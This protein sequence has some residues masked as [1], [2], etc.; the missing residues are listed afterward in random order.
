MLG[1][2]VFGLV[3]FVC[4]AFG[5]GAVVA[6]GEAEARH[7]EM[8]QVAIDGITPE[9]ARDLML[10]RNIG[11]AEIVDCVQGFWDFVFELTAA[12]DAAWEQISSEVF[13][14][15]PDYR[16]RLNR[17]APDV[18]LEY[19][20]AGVLAAFPCPE[21]KNWLMSPL[22]FCV[23]WGQFSFSIDRGASRGINVNI[24][25]F[26]EFISRAFM[27]ADCCG[28]SEI[29]IAGQSRHIDRICFGLGFEYLSEWWGHL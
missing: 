8:L 9:F 22:V 10:A 13:A 6:A 14:L 19:T 18:F 2:M 23:E 5:A 27:L 28:Y 7:V 21:S 4:V 1:K 25:Y 12:V 3:I 15:F 11:P 16:S 20:N 26:E 24:C 29:G 17:L